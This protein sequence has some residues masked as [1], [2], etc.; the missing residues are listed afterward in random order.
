M[1]GGAPGAVTAT[2]PE[3][4]AL[5]EQFV[6]LPESAGVVYLFALDPAARPVGAHTVARAPAAG[7]CSKPGGGR[8]EVGSFAAVTI[9][10]LDRR[11]SSPG[12]SSKPPPGRPSTGPPTR[13]DKNPPFPPNHPQ[14]PQPGN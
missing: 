5:G 4:R 10:L 3:N 14:Q 6:Q 7:V 11:P 12:P 2:L 8:P 9:P 13:P 1:T